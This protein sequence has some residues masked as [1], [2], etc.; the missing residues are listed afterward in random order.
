M[1]SFEEIEVDGAIIDNNIDH[2][3]LILK[4]NYPYNNLE[5]EIDNNITLNQKRSK[6]ILSAHDALGMFADRGCELEV[7]YIGQVFGEN[8]ERLATDRLKSHS[9]L[10]RILMDY[11]SSCPDKQLLVALFEFTPQIYASFDGLSGKYTATNEE[12]NNHFN[13]VISNPLKSNQII[14]ITEAAMIN[15]FKPSYNKD[16]IDNFP[17]KGHK[18][19]NNIMI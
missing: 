19:Y 4:C 3:Q 9:T 14:N 16:F 15:L 13:D 1:E 2:R 8:G 5:V 6:F 11:Y 7:I 10:Q 17:D 18:S 12:E